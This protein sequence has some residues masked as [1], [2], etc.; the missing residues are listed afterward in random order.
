MLEAAVKK[1]QASIHDS[2]LGMP[3]DVK[4]VGGRSMGMT[5]MI[6]ST[7]SPEGGG[8][9]SCVDFD[10]PEVG[11][12]EFRIREKADAG[13]NACPRSRWAV[14]QRSP[15]GRGVSL[16]NFP[17]GHPSLPQARFFGHPYAEFANTALQGYCCWRYL[18]PERIVELLAPTL[19]HLISIARSLA[20]YSPC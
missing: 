7:S 18:F 8:E 13:R 12:G 15:A 3:H 9:M 17:A 11:I 2:V 16:L 14:M 19:Q 10:L 20:R 6:V 1:H 4:A 5:L